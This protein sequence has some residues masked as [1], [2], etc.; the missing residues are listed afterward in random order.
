MTSPLWED[1]QALDAFPFATA[2]N[3]MEDPKA[4]ERFVQ[5]AARNRANPYEAIRREAAKRR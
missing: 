5:A 3:M 4:R 1:I 2:A